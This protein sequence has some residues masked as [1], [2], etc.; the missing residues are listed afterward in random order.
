M[1]VRGS[2]GLP[3][4]MYTYKAEGRSLDVQAV[5]VYEIRDGW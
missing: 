5:R 3:H 2:G 4:G 1:L